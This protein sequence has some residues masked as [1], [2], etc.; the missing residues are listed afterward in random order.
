LLDGDQLP[1]PQLPT[2]K[3]SNTPTTFKDLG[4]GTWAWELGVGLFG[5]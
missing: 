3:R 2:P 4:V 1:I 5:S